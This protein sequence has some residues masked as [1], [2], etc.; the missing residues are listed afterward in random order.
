MMAY[1]LTKR[2]TD[3]REGRE[4]DEAEQYRDRDS[5]HG[6]DLF[7]RSHSFLKEPVL[8]ANVP[9]RAM[10]SICSFLSSRYMMHDLRVDLSGLLR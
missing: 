2:A 7:P 10:F 5:Q 3:L 1:A 8:G 6:V 4:S 9:F